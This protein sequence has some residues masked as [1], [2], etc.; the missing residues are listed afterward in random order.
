M[1]YLRILSRITLLGNGFFG[2]LL[3]SAKIEKEADDE[4]RAYI[5]INE[6]CSTDS[7]L[8][9]IEKISHDERDKKL[10][11]DGLLPSAFSSDVNNN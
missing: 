1:R 2:I 9:A 7:L 5:E 8:S 4:A 10:D 6:D 3:N 11:I